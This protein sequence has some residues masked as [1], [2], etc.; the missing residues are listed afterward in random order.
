ME[1]VFLVITVIGL[2]ASYEVMMYNKIKKE[3][4]RDNKKRCCD[5]DKKKNKPKRNK[6]VSKAKTQNKRK[7]RS[8][9]EKIEK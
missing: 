1:V 6:K 9:K 8:S 5:S 3:N 4:E 7:S 2:Y